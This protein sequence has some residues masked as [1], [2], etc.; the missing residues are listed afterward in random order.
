MRT[1]TREDLEIGGIKPNGW[2]VV[3]VDGH[4]FRMYGR[5]FIGMVLHGD[6]P[7]SAYQYKEDSTYSRIRP[8]P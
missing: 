2:Y 1:L 4:E 5:A 3:R 8:K 7:V 6:L